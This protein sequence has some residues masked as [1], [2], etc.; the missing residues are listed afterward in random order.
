MIEWDTHGGV[1]HAEDD[2]VTMH[3][4]RDED[5]DWV[6]SWSVG[7]IGDDAPERLH[8]IAERVAKVIGEL[9]DAHLE[10]RQE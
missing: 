8:V 6:L 5:G 7:F 9:I 3:L 1:D 4:G 10:R 2:D